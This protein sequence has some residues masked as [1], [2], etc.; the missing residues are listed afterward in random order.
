M[1]FKLYE[2]NSFRKILVEV[3]KLNE[4]N[5]NIFNEKKIFFFKSKF[6]F[7]KRKL[8]FL[9]FGFFQF[10]ERFSELKKNIDLIP[11]NASISTIGKISF[12][13]NEK[14]GFNPILSLKKINPNTY[15]NYSKNHNQNIRKE[16]N[17]AKKEKIRFEVSEDG[18]WLNQFYELMSEQYTRDHRMVFQPKELF[19][20]FIKN[21]MAI[22]FTASKD[23]KLY[24]AIF[25]LKDGDVIHYN[26]GVRKKYKNLNLLTFIIANAINYSVQINFK[27][28]DFG[29]TPLS[30]KGLLEFKKKWNTDMF[31]LFKNSKLKQDK[32]IDLNTSYPFARR[33]FSFIPPV[34]NRRLMKYIVPIF[35]R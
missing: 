3:Y 26:W 33:I 29:A 6:F 12:L 10:S 20:K 24:A 21:K 34:I 31:Y 18:K 35:I 16:I 22:I 30:D 4:I 13:E 28:F 27:F 19:E 11:N 14:I 2:S 32:S 7:K 1:R 8:I 5:L 23:K 15:N 9:P 25:C 17:K